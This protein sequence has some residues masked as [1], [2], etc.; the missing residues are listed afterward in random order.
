MKRTA[1]VISYLALAATLLPPMLFFAD[2]IGAGEGDPNAIGGKKTSN[3]RSPAQDANRN[4]ISHED[5]Q[6]DDDA[7]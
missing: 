4:A 6:R 3:I 1:Q 2:R 5:E 7:V